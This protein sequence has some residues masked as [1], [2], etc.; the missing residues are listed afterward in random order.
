MAEP[1]RGTPTHDGLGKPLRWP[2]KLAQGCTTFHA[3]VQRHA[4][5]STRRSAQSN[6]TTPPDRNVTIT[7]LSAYTVINSLPDHLD[8]P[9]NNTKLARA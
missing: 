2:I 6:T 9:W 3:K 8:Q 5:S 7:E 1:T 4:R